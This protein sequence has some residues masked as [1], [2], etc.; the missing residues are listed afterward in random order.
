MPGNEKKALEII[1]MVAKENQ[2][3]HKIIKFAYR[4]D[5][6]DYVII[7]ENSTLCSIREKLIESFHEDK[8]GD[9]RREIMFR[10]KNG[11]PI[12]LEDYLDT[13]SPAEGKISV[14]DDI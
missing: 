10:L 2:F 13:P 3:P 7:L 4:D 5:Y 9:L 11:E 6:Q 1:A 14:E 8:S 12:E